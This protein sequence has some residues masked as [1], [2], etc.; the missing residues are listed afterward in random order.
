MQSPRITEGGTTSPP[1]ASN[2]PAL[3][4]GPFYPVT[5]PD[6][7]SACLVREDIAALASHPAALDIALRVINRAGRPVRGALVEVWH[8]D[9][10]GRYRH[11]SAPDHEHTLPGFV[12]YGCA[13]SDD[14]GCAVF[15]T[16][17]PGPYEN[18]GIARAPHVHVQVTGRIDRLV[19][20]MFFP[21]EPGNATDRWYRAASRPGQLL[22]TWA[23]AAQVR[24]RIEWSIV[25]AN[26]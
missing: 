5:K 15:H 9:P 19:T 21:G 26:G 7:V 2:T 23:D 6:P 11:D 25:I 20:Q 18:G 14:D 12:G 17:M 3:L 13:R 8:A 4:L 16:L 24:R 10:Q 1:P 22:G